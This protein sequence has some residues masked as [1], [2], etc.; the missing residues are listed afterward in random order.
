LINR[1]ALA[2]DMRARL[3]D[4]LLQGEGEQV[5]FVFGEATVDDEGVTFHGR[6]VYLVPPS[7]L[8]VQQAFH[9]SLTDDAQA[10]II[11]LAWDK[12]LAI[13]E[14]HSHTDSFW[15]AQFSPSDLCGLR[16]FVPHV[17]WRLRGQPYLAIVVGTSDF[18]A[19]VWRNDAAE[20]LD[21]LE[22]GS[23][24]LSPTGLTLAAL[25]EGRTDRYE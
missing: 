16:D 25:R 22:V 14:L 9:V 3:W 18:D 19:L 20:A 17:R 1:L 2:N 8:L 23:Q 24:V 11:K 21:E 12:Q 10:H 7:E 4:H 13:V 5:A 6:E 15:P